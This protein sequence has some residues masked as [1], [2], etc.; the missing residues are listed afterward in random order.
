[1]QDYFKRMDEEYVKKH[2]PD[3]SVLQGAMQTIKKRSIS[4]IIF[5]SIFFAGAVYGLVWSIGRT[6]EFLADGQDDMLDVC[7]AI[8]VFF[9]LVALVLLICMIITIKRSGKN[10]NDYIA[11]SMKN[12]RLPRNEIEEFER[13]AVASDCYI[14]KLTA[15]L[16]RALSNATNKDGLLT[17]DYIYLAD[18]GQTVIR[19]A[20]LR[21]CSFSEYTY[22]VDVGTRRKKIHNLT[23]CLIA[24]NG[25]S[26]SSDT[27]EKAG[28]ALMAILKERNNT[29][30]TNNG[31]VL[32][33][34]AFNAYRNRVLGGQ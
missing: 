6:L 9:A 34:D 13:Q 4:G 7:I 26:V 29:I 30:D 31:K 16:D 17:R 28:Q 27:T 1:M 19:I 5:I 10:H 24:S 33:E 20:D 32:S 25:V 8:C 18:L 11:D 14:L 3:G 15:G 23:I 2:F 12:S 21:A 22:Y